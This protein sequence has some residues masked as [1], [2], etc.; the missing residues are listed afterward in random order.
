M[1]GVVVEVEKEK[2]NPSPADGKKRPAKKVA[3]Q[4]ARKKPSSRKGKTT[5]AKAGAA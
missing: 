5:P 4:S 3:A 1:H 2:R